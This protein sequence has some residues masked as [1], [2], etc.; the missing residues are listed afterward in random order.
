LNLLAASA[1]DGV[2]KAENYDTLGDAHR[3]Q[4]A[5]QQPTGGERR[6]DRPIEDTMIRLKIGRSAEAHNP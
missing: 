4:E 2:I 1:L 3:Y 6:P 5:E